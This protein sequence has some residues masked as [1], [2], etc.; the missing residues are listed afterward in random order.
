[1]LLYQVT[2]NAA[3]GLSSSLFTVHMLQNLRMGFALMALQSAG[4]AAVRVCAVRA[5]GRA[6]D[7]LGARP[8]LVACSFGITLIPLIWLLPTPDNLWPLLLDTLF[9]GVLWSGHSL[10]AFALPLAI[11]PRN[12][13]PFYLASFSVAAGLAFA[14]ASA[15]GGGLAER[16]PCDLL[17]LGHPFFGLQVTFVL[18]SAARLFAA[19]LALRIV[20]PGARPIGILVEAAMHSASLVGQKIARPLPLGRRN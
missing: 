13:R 9:S 8:I 17:V 19:G 15:A 20:E 18:S 16:L 10:A 2:W 4:V 14:A 7:R 5:W 11:A 12:G 1:M 6:V 3:I